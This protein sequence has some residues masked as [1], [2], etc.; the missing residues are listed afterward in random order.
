MSMPMVP[1]RVPAAGKLSKELQR[2][3]AGHSIRRRAL[4]WRRAWPGFGS[5]PAGHS[6][7]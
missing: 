4:G 1:A 2:A 7:L 6:R 5:E 3:I